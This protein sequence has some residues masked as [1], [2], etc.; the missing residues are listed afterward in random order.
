VEPGFSPFEFGGFGVPV[1]ERHAR[2]LQG[3]DVLRQALAE[4]E[5]MFEGKR[6]AIRP[7]PYT[8]PHPPFYWASTADESL[9]KA[10]AE[11]MPILFGLEAVSQLAKHLARYRTIRAAGG[12]SGDAINHEIA[13]MYVLRRI[14]V[15]DT[16]AKALSEVQEPLLWHREMGTRVHERGEAIVTVLTPDDGSTIQP[17]DG[18]CFGSVATVI[19][20]LYELHALGFRKVIGWFH[21]GNMP[22]ES[23]RRSMQLMASGVI[24]GIK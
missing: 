4:P 19:R 10:G 12:L 6:L 20:Q 11:G 2:F 14:Y 21:F 13:E 17:T 18:E 1:D 9:R 16:D 23:V 24:P 3:F 5:I 7:R 15:A 22:H 8:R